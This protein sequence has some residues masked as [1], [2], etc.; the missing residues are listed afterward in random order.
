M[1][2]ESLSPM[3]LST[4]SVFHPE[5]KVSEFATHYELIELIDGPESISVDVSNVSTDRNLCLLV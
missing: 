4:S 5:N 1:S 3:S 2:H